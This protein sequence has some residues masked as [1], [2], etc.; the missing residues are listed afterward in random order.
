MNKNDWRNKHN[1][2]QVRKG[3][4]YVKDGIHASRKDVSLATKNGWKNWKHENRKWVR[5][6][7][8]GNRTYGKHTYSRYPSYRYYMSNGL[9]H[10]KLELK[11][12]QESK[13]F[14]FKII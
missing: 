7:D 6:G 1:Y 11:Y 3:H 8:T 10:K 13:I 12:L 2:S 9:F 14:F 5:K 4:Q